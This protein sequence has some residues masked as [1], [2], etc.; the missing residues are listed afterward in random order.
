MEENEEG[1]ADATSTTRPDLTIRRQEFEQ[2]VKTVNAALPP[3]RRLPDQILQDFIGYWSEPTQTGNPKLKKEKQETWDT[4][5]RIS[6]WRRLAE[7]RGELPK[8]GPRKPHNP[9]A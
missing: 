8:S 2:E 5:R 4:A 6:T 1:G 3:E 9:R 7:E